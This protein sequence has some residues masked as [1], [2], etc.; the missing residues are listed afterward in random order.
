MVP[1]PDLFREAVREMD[2]GPYRFVIARFHGVGGETTRTAKGTGRTSR[3]VS[4]VVS[5]KANTVSE[6]KAAI[7]GQS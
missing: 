5:L 3:L 2:D 4:R 1:R 6:A 7:P